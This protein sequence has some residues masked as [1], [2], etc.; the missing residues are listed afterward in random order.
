[1]RQWHRSSRASKPDGPKPSDERSRYVISDIPRSRAEAI[2]ETAI[3]AKV[4]YYRNEAQ[5][6]IRLAAAST[7]GDAKVQF[8][9]LAQ[10]YETLAEHAAE[11]AQR[12]RS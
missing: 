1:M 4:E 7:V 2:E 10:Q 11:R 6:L 5:R 8:L 9:A 12:L 3:A